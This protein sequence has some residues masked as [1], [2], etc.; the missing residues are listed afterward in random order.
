ME[1]IN[2]LL[3]T[4]NG[5]KFVLKDNLHLRFVKN[6]QM[7]IMPIYNSENRIKISKLWIWP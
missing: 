4:N 2:S 5:R 1:L 7:H 3:S 6:Y